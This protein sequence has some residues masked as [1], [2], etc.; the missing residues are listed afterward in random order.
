MKGATGSHG[1]RREA[2]I[3]A[4]ITCEFR[5]S[6]MGPGAECFVFIEKPFQRSARRRVA[7]DKPRSAFG[8]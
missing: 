1:G 3:L 2:H 8:P 4:K 5:G 7:E 6:N